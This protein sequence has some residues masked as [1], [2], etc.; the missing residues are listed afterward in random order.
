MILLSGILA[1]IYPCYQAIKTYPKALHYYHLEKAVEVIGAEKRIIDKAFHKLINVREEEREHLA[2][3]LH[4]EAIQ[5]LIGLKFS[6]GN[7][8]EGPQP[9][10]QE[11]INVIIDTLRGICTD[12]R[13]PALDRLGLCAALSSYVDHL[14][15]RSGM[16]IL[17]NPDNPIKRMPPEIE[18][19]L[20]RIAQEALNNT[21]K[22]AKASH[23]EIKLSFYIQQVQ[24]II[25]DNG[26]GF[27]VPERLG[28][29][30]DGG[31]FGLVNMQ[32][33]AAALEGKMNLQSDIGKGTCITVYIPCF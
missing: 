19:A 6:I 1:A 18:L 5:S 27:I 32:E 25:R 13:P 7:Q 12:L 30:I 17:F 3:E 20:F 2:R 9:G 4:D 33:R 8:D 15:A 31:H 29:L 26:E 23:I 16:V 10:L 14:S 11:E 24:L 22:H 28:E 21:W